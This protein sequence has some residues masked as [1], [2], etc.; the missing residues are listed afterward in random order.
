[1]PTSEIKPLMRTASARWTGAIAAAL[2]A[3]RAVVLFRMP[4][5]PGLVANPLFWLVVASALFGAATFRQTCEGS[6]IPPADTL[7]N[8]PERRWLKATALVLGGGVCVSYA[9]NL[10]PQR[11]LVGGW[12][13]AQPLWFAA[14]LGRATWKARLSLSSLAEAA[15]LASILA[16]AATLRLFNTAN[17]PLNFHGDFASFGLQARALLAGN[18]RDFFGTGYAGFPLPGVWPTA[19]MMRIVGDNLTGLAA[20]AGLGGLASLVALYLLTRELFGWRVALFATALLAGDITHIHYSR[21]TS[22]MD[23]VPF[24]AWSIYLGVLGLRRGARRHFALSGIFAGHA[25]L[26][27]YAGRMVIPLGGLAVAMTALAAP[28]VFRA[29]IRGLSIAVIGFLLV[30]GPTLFF[31]ARNRE[32]VNARTRS[33]MVF[34]PPV[35]HH[36]ANKYGIAE[37]DVAGVMREQFKRSA[38]AFWRFND[39][40]TQFGIERNMLE[41]IG[42]ILLI[43]GLGYAAWNFWRPVLAFIVVWGLGYV[44]AGALTVDP[45]FSGRIVGLT[46]P[47]AVLGGLALDRAL[48]L[49]PRGRFW[50]AL[51]VVFGLALTAASG[52]RNW[53][54]YV[55]WGT[56]PRFTQG[57]LHVARFL[58]TQPAKY[59][60]RLA[61]RFFGWKVRELEFLQP[62]RAGESLDPHA[63]ANNSIAWPESPTI[64]V[65]MPEYRSLAQTL[66]IRYP[67]GRLVDGSIPPMK[68]VFWAF[69]T[70]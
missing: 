68:G 53:H 57:Q 43:L 45:P 15:G 59:Q 50:S 31:F 20:F 33:V 6:W 66:Q 11:V 12:L 42:G 62:D 39:S 19:I 51:A 16:L 1:M 35:W 2:A 17:M 13:L 52:A 65:L 61:S 7:A 67:R 32:I 34:D 58:M 63:I 38:E 28:R 23:P 24:L 56:N 22:Y 29:R 60:V 3:W 21:V 70:E 14:F 10:L 37:S 69:F 26:S 49:V 41:P 25:F 54:D 30:M 27:Y 4:E 5:R 8:P 44:I 64:F 36:T 48:R 18:Y 55:A 46:L 9:L 47:V 40:A